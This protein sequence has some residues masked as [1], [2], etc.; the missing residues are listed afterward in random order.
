MRGKKLSNES[1]NMRGVGR[2]RVLH[3]IL[4]DVVETGH[5]LIR[6]QLVWVV[7]WV[8]SHE[9]RLRRA[10]PVLDAGLAKRV[11]AIR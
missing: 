3:Q 5:V 8:D 1:S 2:M 11:P 6:Y 4:C 10:K 9:L 7:A